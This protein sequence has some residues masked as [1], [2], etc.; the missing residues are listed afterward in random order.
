[1]F[2]WVL[3]AAVLILVS[4]PVMSEPVWTGLEA[5]V[6]KIDAMRIVIELTEEHM[7]SVQKVYPTLAAGVT[8]T[9]HA[10]AWT[11]GTVTEIVPINT[12]A[13][14]FD[15]HF[16]TVHDAS[17]AD[18][19]EISFYSNNGAGN[20][21]VGRCRMQRSLGAITSAAVVMQSPIIAA[22][23]AINAAVASK[24]GGGDNVIVSILYHTYE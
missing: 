17:A 5:L 11:L 7:H 1:M 13:S 19:Y 4:L 12:I 10:T 22:N 9:G 15:I 8:V 24:S 6:A 16:V 3:I 14:D 21:E 20:V 18:A 23:S 2:K